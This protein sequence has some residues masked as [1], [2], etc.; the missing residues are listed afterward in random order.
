MNKRFDLIRGGEST[1][2]PPPKSGGES[3]DTSIMK[4]RGGESIWG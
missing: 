2:Q 4:F 3:T 1:N